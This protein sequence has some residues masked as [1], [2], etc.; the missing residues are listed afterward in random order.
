M[1]DVHSPIELD[2][3][4]YAVLALDMN[5]NLIHTRPDGGHRSPVGGLRPV[6]HHFQLEAS[7]LPSWNREGLNSFQTVAQPLNGL[8]RR[9]HLLSIPELNGQPHHRL[10]VKR[11]WEQIHQGHAL[12]A[13][14]RR[15]QAG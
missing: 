10:Q 7:L 12:H 6:L 15:H 11:L 8:E 5:T 1:K 13:I 4:K 3:V 2:N 9:P 14:A